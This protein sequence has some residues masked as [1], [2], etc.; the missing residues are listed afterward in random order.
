M[1]FFL[2][3]GSFCALFCA[4]I[5]LYP[6]VKT[7]IHIYLRR[8][9]IKKRILEET[10]PKALQEAATNYNTYNLSFTEWLKYTLLAAAATVAVSVMF[11]RNAGFTVAMLPLAFLYPGVKKKQLI[12]RRKKR[13]T[14]QFRDL[15]LSL[16]SSLSAG[17]SLESAFFTAAKD[18][19][20]LYPDGDALIM[21]E[22]DIITHK[23]EMNEPITE[24]LA[25]FARRADIEDITSFSDVI[26][27]C[28]NT[29]GN[30][31]AVVRNAADIISQK[32]EILNEIDVIT[33][34]QKMSQKILGVM[35]FVLLALIQA[36]SPDYIKPLYTAAGHMVMAVV[37]TL[38]V[39]SFY[40]GARIVDIKV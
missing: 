23:L 6:A 33:T 20:M 10:A 21:K 39:L 4:A 7:K 5:F 34:Q 24:A 36:G 32:A 14:E 30:L 37:L 15:L 16:S 38:L 19:E 3:L 9:A 1:L 40:I 17:K 8:N 29:G 11:F 27:V 26:A 25:D 28:G 18:L 22:L 2:L 35:P 12:I 31:N 13:L